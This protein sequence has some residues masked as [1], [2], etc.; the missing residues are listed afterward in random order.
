MPQDIR[1]EIID[2]VHKKLNKTMF[3]RNTTN[4]EIDDYPDRGYILFNIMIWM[5]PRV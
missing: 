3:I 1:S 4:I 2:D 5:D